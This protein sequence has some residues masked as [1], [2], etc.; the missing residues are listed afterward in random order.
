[1]IRQHHYDLMLFRSD[2]IEQA[3]NNSHYQI[4]VTKHLDEAIAM[5]A[6]PNLSVIV[7]DANIAE[8]ELSSLF[9][10]AKLNRPEVV[11]LL[12]AGNEHTG[13]LKHFLQN[14]YIHNVLDRTWDK[15]TIIH[16]VKKSVLFHLTIVKRMD[17][18]A[19]STSQ[20]E[21]IMTCDAEQKLL[22]ANAAF[23]IISE[24]QTEE[25]AQ[26]QCQL[27]QEDINFSG[28]QNEIERSL[29]KHGF[30]SGLVNLIKKGGKI[31]SAWLT[32]I[33][34]FHSELSMRIYS[35]KEFT[36]VNNDT[37]AV[38]EI[39]SKV[40]ILHAD[41]DVLS[42]HL[43]K[44]SQ[45]LPE[46]TN[47]M[48][49]LVKIDRYSEI[50]HVIKFVGISQL[51][52]KLQQR[53]TQSLPDL[54][55]AILNQKQ[56]C[57][58]ILSILDTDEDKG[59]ERVLNQI[60]TVLNEPVWIH[61]KELV[62]GYQIGHSHGLKQDMDSLAMLTAAKDR[63]HVPEL[64]GQPSNYGQQSQRKEYHINKEDI[65]ESLRYNEFELLYQP[66]VDIGQNNI[67][68]IETFLRWRHPIHGL[69]N[70][71]SFMDLFL[72]TH[73]FE[74]LAEWT[75]TEA[76]SKLKGY[77]SNKAENVRLC[78]N[79]TLSQM[80]SG[81]VQD[82]IT[83]AIKRFP[84]ASHQ[85]EV[86]LDDMIYLVE[87]NSLMVALEKLYSQ[88]IVLSLN[89][90]DMKNNYIKKLDLKYFKL[91]KFSPSVLKQ[92]FHSKQA[93]QKLLEIV[94]DVKHQKGLELAAVGIEDEQQLQ[95][96]KKMGMHYFQGAYVLPPV[97]INTL[98][99]W[100]HNTIYSTSEVQ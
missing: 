99:K 89:H 30:W 1:M 52:N 34:V 26:K 79:L 57:M 2:V 29:Q 5:L 22:S 42:Y 13:L 90:T 47:L 45:R 63:L 32:V 100:L 73:V 72:D 48:L 35:F 55:V 41:D 19:I 23:H 91:V 68:T 59:S 66:Q 11:R 82:T 69:I 27:I 38:I 84:F 24:H 80:L 70:P 96:I 88:G 17:T 71:Q 10:Q 7:A 83:R 46:P 14:G 60:M 20:L 76:C 31:Y 62:L 51:V 53:L 56:K 78:F 98:Q 12:A 95:M 28:L 64:V 49:S 77:F 61:D 58:A 36:H 8:N 6:N 44:A 85:Y 39:N 21:A 43:H 50:E 86:E 4:A 92:A 97:E 9:S 65:F 75:I 54:V 87:T 16:A 94:D 67:T 74:A 3:L 37:N 81:T 18:I 15:E 25:I 40:K 93:E 33:N